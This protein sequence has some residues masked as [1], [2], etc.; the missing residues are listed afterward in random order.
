VCSQALS[1]RLANTLARV[2]Y[3]F[4]WISRQVQVKAASHLRFR[5]VQFGSPP[6]RATL[7]HM[8]VMKQ[9]VE[10][11]ADSG[12][13]PRSLPQSS[14]GRLEVSSVLARSYRRM[15]IS[16]SSSAAVSWQLAH[17]ELR[18]WSRNSPEGKLH[19]KIF[20][21]D[22]DEWVAPKI[23]KQYSRKPDA[24]VILKAEKA[25]VT[26][27]SGEDSRSSQAVTSS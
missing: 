15:M 3:L 12:E 26:A 2:A 7:E 6:S 5:R 14:T 23:A 16:R 8:A 19:R 21:E 20:G 25:A 9:A 27:F 1:D 17:F 13:I 24:R 4:R 11:R 18:A 10:H 22:V